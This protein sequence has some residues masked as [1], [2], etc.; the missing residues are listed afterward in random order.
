MEAA[1]PVAG[2]VA[3][4]AIVRQGAGATINGERFAGF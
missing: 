1:G 4:A 3:P 2:Q